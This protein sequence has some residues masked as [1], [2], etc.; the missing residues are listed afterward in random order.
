MILEEDKCRDQSVHSD[1]NS[2][3]GINRVESSSKCEVTR[4]VLDSK[5]D[6]RVSA[7]ASANKLSEK[8]EEK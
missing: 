3:Y 5:F 8:L 6:G 4:I 7:Y 2:L 1:Q